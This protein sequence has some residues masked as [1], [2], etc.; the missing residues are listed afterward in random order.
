MDT[1]LVP[2]EFLVQSLIYFLTKGMT[3][4]SVYVVSGIMRRNQMLS[5]E[6]PDKEDIYMVPVKNK[7]HNY[8]GVV[9]DSYNDG[10]EKRED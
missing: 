5:Y 9:R 2:T 7:Y 4:C 8:H 10:K 3:L 6:W 1:P